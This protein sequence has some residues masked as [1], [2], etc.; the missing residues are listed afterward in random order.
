MSTTIPIQ[1]LDP[2]TSPPSDRSIRAVVTLSWPYSSSTRQCALLL[3]ERDFRLRA[4]GGQIR[5]EFSGPAARAVAESK[6]GIGDE[7]L[8]ELGAGE[9]AAGGDAAIRVP[10]KSVGKL[11]FRRGVR[12]TVQKEGNEDVEIIVADDAVEEEGQERSQLESTPTKATSPATAFRSSIGGPPGSVAIYS[13]PAYMRKAAKFS[14][15]EG[16]SR[17]FDDDDDWE[18]QDL[19]RKK[20]RTSMGDVKSW[21]VVDRTPSPERPASKEAASVDVDM[22]D[23]SQTGLTTGED[24]VLNV[25][26]L[27]LVASAS[28]QTPIPETHSAIS[29]RQHQYQHQHQQNKAPNQFHQPLLTIRDQVHPQFLLLMLPKDNRWATEKQLLILQH[30]LIQNPSWYLQ[31][32]GQA[33]WMTL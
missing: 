21:R 26:D 9:W 1:D 32:L 2:S 4:R 11:H 8:L 12:L 24:T 22:E 27:P 17:L 15:L 28:S 7:V 19:P 29:P 23:V 33:S 20:A 30:Y 13:S 5:V 6:P 18:N 16:I 3:S 31:H 10:G 14:Y 25:V